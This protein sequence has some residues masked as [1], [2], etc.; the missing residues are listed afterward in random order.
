M[1][2]SV[3]LVLWLVCLLA[4]L[5][6]DPASQHRT[7]W[8][9]WVPV[10]W[11]FI[12]ATRLPSQWLNAN[13]GIVISAE[14]Q[15]QG[16]PT[17]RLVYTTL[18]VLAIVILATRRFPWGPFFQRNLALS[19]FLF[20]CLL[21]VAWSDFP[22]VAF[23]RWFR[24]MGDYL[25]LLVVLSSP[26]PA[27][28][29]RTTLRRL[30]YLVIPLSVVLV[31]YYPALSIHYSYWTGAPEYTGAATSKNTLGSLCLI[32]GLVFCWETVLRWP[33]RKK[34][35]VQLSFVVNAGLFAM[36]LWLLHLS[37]SATS[38]VCLALG[39][40]VIAVA[41]TRWAKHHSGLFKFLMPAF[42][43]LYILL[44]LGFDMTG[45]MAA[46]LGR[47]PDLTGRAEI[48]RTLLSTHTNP[49]LG[50][51]YETFWMGPRLEWIWQQRGHINEAH[52][53]YLD[54]YLNLGLIGLCLLII[55]LASAYRNMCRG[56][57]RRS[58]I[59]VLGAAS[60]TLL[61]FYSVTEAAFLNGMIWMT[62]LLGTV[63]VPRT[64]KARARTQTSGSSPDSA[65]PPLQEA[66]NL[67]SARLY[68]AHG[69]P[70]TVL[71]VRPEFP[72]NEATHKLRA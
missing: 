70:E 3:A 25:V 26:Q 42:F 27:E 67:I 43:L 64:V 53:G 6:F 24:D 69:Q 31:K 40:I 36:V 22:F 52:N 41:Q 21:S 37:N 59:A 33:D 1:S 35:R 5:R 34:R 49:L 68:A 16:N 60:W 58:G 15:E 14:A 57:D 51:G 9:L 39:C 11:M 13:G 47:N 29:V 38:H 12:A 2:P 48:W 4:L 30:C 10:I 7:G 19:A 61:L 50:T 55:L 20:F 45:E 62:F 66:E 18:I 32:S 44:S 56:L 65:W 8:T 54:V 72:S 46:D 28:A 71:S 63:V 17:D 23:K